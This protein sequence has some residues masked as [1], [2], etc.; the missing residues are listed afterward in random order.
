[1]YLLAAGLAYGLGNQPG[2]LA[3]MSR[4]PEELEAL[5]AKYGDWSEIWADLGRFQKI[6][7][8]G[9]GPNYGL[10]CEAMLKVKEMSLSWVEAYHTLEFRHGPMSLVDDQT[11]VVGFLS[12]RARPAEMAV[13][14]DLQKL[15]A[16]VVVCDGARAG[17]IP[18]IPE[19]HLETRSEI[20]E[21]L[22]GLL[23]LPLMQRL[24]YQR[25]LKKNL[26]P[27]LPTHLQAVI[28]L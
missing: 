22:R 5:I 2:L 26:N 1:M 10:A 12:E 13:L 20:N 27:D 7:F 3:E 16:V 9:N 4:L 21:W 23:Y 11:L 6:F 17:E 24:G 19:Y 18:W 28:Y 25:A 15:G 14:R 8:L